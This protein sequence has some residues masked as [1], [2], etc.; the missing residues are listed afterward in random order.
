MTKEETL[1]SM[2]STIMGMLLGEGGLSS[3]FCP[4]IQ[5]QS[6]NLL[7]EKMKNHLL[8]DEKFRDELTN[9]LVNV[10]INKCK[11]M[12]VEANMANLPV[13]LYPHQCCLQAAHIAAQIFARE[14]N[15]KR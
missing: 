14:D 12:G 7:M 13:V 6:L 10:Y 2:K 4:D 9:E 11:L 8:T 3:D 5:D 15:L 1:N